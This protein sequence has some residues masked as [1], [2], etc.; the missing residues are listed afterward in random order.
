MVSAH[1]EL[2]RGPCAMQCHRALEA[3]EVVG[4]ATWVPPV[5]EAD[6]PIKT[7]DM[8]SQVSLPS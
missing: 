7:L 3:L 2:R 1:S 5:H 4:L 8:K 6:P